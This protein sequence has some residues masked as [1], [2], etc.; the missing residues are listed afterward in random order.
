MLNDFRSGLKTLVFGYTLDSE[1]GDLVHSSI[2]AT[3]SDVKLDLLLS[4][5]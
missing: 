5:H 1:K 3:G 4:R 2:V